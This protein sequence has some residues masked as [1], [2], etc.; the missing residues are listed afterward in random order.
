MVGLVITIF[1]VVWIAYSVSNP[2][3]PQTTTRSTLISASTSSVELAINGTNF[4]MYVRH[5]PIGGGY[6]VSAGLDLFHNLQVRVFILNASVTLLNMTT[7]DGAQR[8]INM[9]SWVAESAYIDPLPGAYHICSE[10][11][12]FFEIPK[13]ATIRITIYIQDP[14]ATEVIIVPRYFTAM[15]M[16]VRTTTST[17]TG[18]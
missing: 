12:P 11:G 3:S 5:D 8:R 4:S 13:D 6:F 10:F 9:T 14:S 16:P 17:C 1:L 18:P 7:R 15:N 2:P